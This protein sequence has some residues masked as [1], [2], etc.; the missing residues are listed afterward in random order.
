M[1]GAE[2]GFTICRNPDT[3]RAPDIAFVSAGRVA[4][5]V[6]AFFPGHPDLAV[7]VVSPG[8]DTVAEV[9]EKVDQWLAAGTMSVWVANPTNRSLVVYR[10]ENY[11]MQYR[12]GDMLS[13]EPTL[14]GFILEIATIYPS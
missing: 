1:V 9:T 10:A 7:E 2:T 5:Q 13:D 4:R 11:V 8:G 6:P 3:V 14:P 12:V